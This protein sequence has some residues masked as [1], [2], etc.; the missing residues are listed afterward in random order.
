MGDDPVQAANPN[1]RFKSRKFIAYM[2]SNL[3]WKLLIAFMVWKGQS[4]FILM[5]VVIVSGCV[6]IGYILGQASLDAFLGWADGLHFRAPV[7]QEVVQIPVTRSA[8]GPL[9]ETVPF[10]ATEPAGPLAASES[11]IVMDAAPDK[12]EFDPDKG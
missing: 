1:S 4:D 3:V 12:V 7:G 11:A 8:P 10:M 2:V 5:T 6:D 9:V